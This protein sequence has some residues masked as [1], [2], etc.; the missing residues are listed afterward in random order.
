M[1]LEIIKN[2]VLALHVIGV[3]SLLGGSLVQLSSIKSGTTRII[4]PILDGAWTMLITGVILVGL[5][6]PLGN[7]VDNVKITVKLLVLV[8]IVVIALVNRKKEKLAAW[9]IP[10]LAGLTVVN[11]LIAT[12]W[13][14]YS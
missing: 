9:V 11:I 1:A 5:Q 8:A 10:T 7:D 6:Y 12:V 2:I 14:N 4:R 13:R 3:A